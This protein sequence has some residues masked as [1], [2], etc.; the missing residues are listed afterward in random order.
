[1]HKEVWQRKDSPKPKKKKKLENEVGEQENLQ[2]TLS[3]VCAQK[4]IGYF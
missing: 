3:D 4:A 1:M 2:T